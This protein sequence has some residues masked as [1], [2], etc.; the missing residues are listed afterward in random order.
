MNMSIKTNE[1]F[2]VFSSKGYLTTF[3]VSPDL[4]EHAIKYNLHGPESGRE[5][6]H[7]LLYGDENGIYPE[8]IKFPVIYRNEKGK[9][10]RDML[11]M[12][13]DGNCF[14]ISD[15]MKVLMEENQ[16]TGWKSYPV[17]VYDKKGNEM[18]GYHGFTVTGKGGNTSMLKPWAEI[19][20]DERPS[21]ILWDKCLWDGSDVFRIWPNYLTITAKTMRLFKKNE[22]TAASYSPLSKLVGII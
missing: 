7:Q 21:F 17:I 8:Y 3:D 2:Y 22:I 12:R 4:F 13:F 18:L 9:K 11:D 10:M 6:H 16:I 1:E 15:R 19:G 20:M 5:I 14:L